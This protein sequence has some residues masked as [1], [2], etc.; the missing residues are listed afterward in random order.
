MLLNGTIYVGRD[1]AHKRMIEALDRGEKL[2]FDIFLGASELVRGNK[3]FLY[4]L[5][6]ADDFP[7][8]FQKFLNIDARVYEESPGFLVLF[9]TGGNVVTQCLFLPQPLKKP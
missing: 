2:P 5:E 3:I 1:A 9:Y 7:R 6:F 8:R 4:V